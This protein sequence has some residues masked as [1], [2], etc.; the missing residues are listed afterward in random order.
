MHL[1]MDG[2]DLSVSGDTQRTAQRGIVKTR[3]LPKTTYAQSQN[4][5]KP[6]NFKTFRSNKARKA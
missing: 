6:H 2:V 3:F 5:W 1:A 4:I